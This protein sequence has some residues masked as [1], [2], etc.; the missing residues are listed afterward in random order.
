MDC[1]IKEALSVVSEDHT[2]FSHPPLKTEIPD[3]FSPRIKERG[4]LQEHP[5]VP[6]TERLHSIKQEAEEMPGTR[7]PAVGVI[8][9]DKTEDVGDSTYQS[10]YADIPT[11][12]SAPPPHT[13]GDEEKRVIVPADPLVWSQDHVSQWLDWAVKEYGLCDVNTSEMQGVDG[14]ELCRMTREDFLRMA[15]SY[16]TEMLMSHLAYLRQ[17]SPT[18]TYSVVPALPAHQP[19]PRHPVKTEPLYEDVRR[20]SWSSSGGSVHRVSPPLTP[21]ITSTTNTV[22]SPQDPYQVLGPTSSRLSNPGSGQIQL[23]Q[24]LL[25]LLSDSCNSSCIAWEGLNGEFKM[26]DPDEVARRWGER[27]SKPNMNY[28]KLSRAL[29][30]YYDKNIMSKVHGKRYA[31]R[32]DF[33]GIQVVQHSHNN[34]PPTPKYPEGNY[35]SPQAKAPGPLPSHHPQSSTLIPVQYF[36]SAPTGGLYPGQGITRQHG[37]LLGTHLGTFY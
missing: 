12:G 15:S 1:T 23:W 7:I 37:G 32:F 13:N 18:F 34:D 4:A 25:E 19:A 20:Q 33:Q 27:K 6:S 10:T 22:R 31:Y 2:M 35:Y 3:D 11:N 21:G 28:D 26:T 14:K 24:F 16:S 5:W 29:R 30:Y 9:V 17:N 8:R 36:S